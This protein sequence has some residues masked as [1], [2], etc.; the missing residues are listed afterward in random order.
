MYITIFIEETFDFPS[1]AAGYG[2]EIG[3][4]SV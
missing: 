1:P 3:I 4:E 2:A